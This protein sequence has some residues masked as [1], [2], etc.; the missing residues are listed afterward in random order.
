MHSGFWAVLYDDD[1]HLCIYRGN[2]THSHRGRG[3][4]WDD[5]SVGR[6]S[7]HHVFLDGCGAYGA[8]RGWA[9]WGSPPATESST[10]R[11]LQ[12]AGTTLT[13]TLSVPSHTFGFEI[14][15][16]DGLAQVITAQFYNGTTLL[17]S[18]SLTMNWNSGA[19]LAGG[20]DSTTITSVVITAPASA[21]GFGM[22]EFRYGTTVDPGAP[23]PN[24]IVT[25][26]LSLLLLAAGTLLVRMRKRTEA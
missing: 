1:A 10:P 5:V 11:V 25:G 16:D 8:D 26:G 22:A 24:T 18:T 3:W 17:G 9:T 13:L 15:P 7:N 19:L 23:A 14:E 21:G 4:D 20:S 12:A 2:H 6:H